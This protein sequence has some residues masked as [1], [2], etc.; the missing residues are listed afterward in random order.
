MSP[1]A[2]DAPPH[3]QSPHTARGTDPVSQPLT[4]QRPRAELIAELYDLYAA[5]MFAYC[6]D[7]LGD[8]GSASDVLV[9]VLPA[10]PDT[11][12]PRAALYAFARREIHRRDIVYSPPTVDPLIDPATALVE[13]SLRDLRSH[14]REVLVLCAV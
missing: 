8:L 7:Q 3:P 11:A 6:A 1:Q 12:P 14:H 5:G 4:G 2:P 10:V 13:R 9:S